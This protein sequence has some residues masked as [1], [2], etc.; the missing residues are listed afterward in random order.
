MAG[1]DLP[2]ETTLAYQWE[3]DDRDERKKYLKDYFNFSI[4]LGGAFYLA[5]LI[6]IGVSACNPPSPAAYVATLAV[7]GGVPSVMLYKVMRATTHAERHTDPTDRQ[8]LPMV[9]MLKELASHVADIVKEYA[10]R[11]ST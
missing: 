6:Y 2:K 9:E 3:L 4:A 7:L 1:G 10:N 8:S 5:L 11:K